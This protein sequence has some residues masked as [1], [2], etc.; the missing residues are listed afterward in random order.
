[1]LRISTF[2]GVLLVNLSLI[3]I[4]QQFLVDYLANNY[5]K[6]SEMHLSQDPWISLL[7]V[8]KNALNAIKCFEHM[9]MRKCQTIM[10]ELLLRAEM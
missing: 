3:I 5:T 4:Q 10:P 1:M 6:I 9:N 7:H 2:I 8:Q